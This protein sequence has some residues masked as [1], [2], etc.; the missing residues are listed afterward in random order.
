[1]PRG[2]QDALVAAF[3]KA[4]NSFWPYPKGALD[5]KS[6]LANVIHSK[7]RT[8]LNNLIADTQGTIVIGGRSEGK[9][10][11]PTIVKDV[12]LDDVLMDESVQVIYLMVTSLTA[13]L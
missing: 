6:E 8:R 4:Y 1:V 12:Q 5:D 7:S 3:Q 11:E 2:Q 10:I 13:G 9:R